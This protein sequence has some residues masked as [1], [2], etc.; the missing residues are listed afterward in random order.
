M[1]ANGCRRRQST[2]YPRVEEGAIDIVDDQ[3]Y[4]Q[5]TDVKGSMGDAKESR[6]S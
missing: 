2:Y 4:K 1:K 6:L 3:G 5:V